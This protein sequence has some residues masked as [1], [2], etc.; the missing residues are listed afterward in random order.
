MLRPR[1]FSTRGIIFNFIVGVVVC[2]NGI[3]MGVEANLGLLGPA[4]PT[5]TGGGSICHPI[6]NQPPVFDVY[7]YIPCKQ[8]ENV[9]YQLVMDGKWDVFF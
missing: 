4:G 6:P 2:A 8:W 1:C 9:T 7:I 5:W 3:L